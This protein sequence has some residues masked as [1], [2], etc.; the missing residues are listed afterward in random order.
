LIDGIELNLIRNDL[1]VS[2][3]Y[4]KGVRLTKS[5]FK[6]LELRLQRTLGIERWSVCVAPNARTSYA[7]MPIEIEIIL[8]ERRL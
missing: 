6:K 3:A 5:E 4:E 2:K 8:D 7:L 1:V